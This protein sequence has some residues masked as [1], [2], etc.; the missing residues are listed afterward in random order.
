MRVVQM[1]MEAQGGAKGDVSL[2][3]VDLTGNAPSET[4]SHQSDKRNDALMSQFCP[5]V[6]AQLAME[7]KYTPLLR[8]QIGQVRLLR[9][10]ATVSIPA[11]KKDISP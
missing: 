3:R 8:R 9:E 4:S 11:G 1:Q 5:S 2:G 10:E 7:A 6:W